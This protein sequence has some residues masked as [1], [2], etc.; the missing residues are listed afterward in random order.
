M[1]PEELS[2]LERRLSSYRDA[3]HDCTRYE[4]LARTLA[5][6]SESSTECDVTHIVIDVVNK[7][8]RYMTPDRGK[9]TV[10]ASICSIKKDEHEGIVNSF[11]SWAIAEIGSK[12]AEANERKKMS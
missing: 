9:M 6:I 12:L 8:V 4:K 2:S 3:E 10:G 1:T 11:L 5:A 7:E